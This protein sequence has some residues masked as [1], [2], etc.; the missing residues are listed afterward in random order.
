MK[1]RKGKRASP[2]A[3]RQ[4]TEAQIE[5]DR[6][7]GL[8]V[9]YVRTEIAKLGQR[10]FAARLGVTNPAVS[11]WENGMGIARDKLDEI[12][13]QFKIWRDWLHT[14]VG[15]PQPTEVV[16]VMHLLS[17]A[18]F[19]AVAE[20]IRYQYSQQLGA[21]EE[22]IETPTKHRGHDEIDNQ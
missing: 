12:V 6:E 11:N 2:H 8:R 15:T 4:K 16:E 18:R 22:E 9:K 7:I 20:F 21:K 14:G 1:T 13:S 10:D 5:A 19:E 3:R 17:S